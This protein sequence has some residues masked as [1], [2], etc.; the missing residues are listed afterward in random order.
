MKFLHSLGFFSLFLVFES[1]TKVISVNLNNAAPQIAIE[2]NITNNTGPYQIQI[3][4]TVN[5]SESN[6]FPP[7][8][9]AVVAITDSTLGFTDTLLESSPGI[10]T[11]QHLPTGAPGHTYQL[12]VAVNGQTYTASSTMP[13]PV[14]LDSVS[15]QL[16]N[17]FGDSKTNPIVNF[18]D[19]VNIANFY[20][21]TEY[22][23]SKMINQIF[24]FSDRLS[25]GKYIHQQ[26]FNDS[27]Y[28]NTGDT[29]LLQMNCV[30][31]KVW[32][33][34]NTLGQVTNGNN[35]QSTA[36]SNPLS[37]IS[38]NALGYFSASTLSSKTS[39]L[40]E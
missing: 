7:V 21:F 4:K 18:Q 24:V 36:P 39:I 2:G 37:N 31:N 22:V 30:D 38:N 14:I 33:F 1:C 40:N 26:L 25:D 6:L 35:F 15:F 32:N 34:F 5:F 16:N 20:T 10:Y 27:S 13:Q 3:I 11:T 17:R 23:N 28:I 19:P 29:I 8:S 9:G 12:F